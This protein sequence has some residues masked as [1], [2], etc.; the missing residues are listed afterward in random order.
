MI[1]HT[2]FL[3]KRIFKA[4][5]EVITVPYA[6]RAVYADMFIS[7]SKEKDVYRM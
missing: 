7:N 3:D 6:A 4:I 1:N 5:E 2:T